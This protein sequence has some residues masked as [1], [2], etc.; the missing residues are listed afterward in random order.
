[1]AKEDSKD[2]GKAGAK[3]NADE[4]VAGDWWLQQTRLQTQLTRLQK[5]RLEKLHNLLLESPSAERPVNGTSIFGEIFRIAWDQLTE[6][7]L[8]EREPEKT[9]LQRFRE[10]KAAR[11]ARIEAERE[12][13]KQPE[14]PQSETEGEA[15]VKDTEALSDEVVTNSPAEGGN[16][17]APAVPEI[18]AGLKLSLEAHFM[19]K[20]THSG[21]CDNCGSRFTAGSGVGR[22]PAGDGAKARLW[23][24]DCCDVAKQVGVH[25]RALAAAT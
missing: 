23:G 25:L 5:R 8:V 15:A 17:L 13:A 3:L 2:A 9:A 20:C 12:A 10:G 16:G 21:T 18:I 19:P 22:D 4:Q 7:G 14:S 24:P 1:M 6:E 11:D